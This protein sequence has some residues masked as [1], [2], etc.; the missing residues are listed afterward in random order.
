MGKF[1]KKHLC[2]SKIIVLGGMTTDKVNSKVIKLNQAK[3][4]D[5]LVLVQFMA[6][7][8]NNLIFTVS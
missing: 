6:V 4:F 7:V 8:G 2:L 3:E 1:I 5:P